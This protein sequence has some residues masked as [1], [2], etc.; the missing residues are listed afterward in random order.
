MDKGN[1]NKKGLSVAQPTA[2]REEQIKVEEPTNIKPRTY[3]NFSKAESII[4][5]ISRE[6]DV[7]EVSMST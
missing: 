2:K 7:K 4:S 6:M 5:L 1:V 3:E